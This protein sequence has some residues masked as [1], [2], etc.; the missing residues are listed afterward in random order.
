MLKKLSTTAL[1][2]IALLTISCTGFANTSS[3]TTRTYSIQDLK[4]VVTNDQS[5]RPIFNALKT[6]AK[7]NIQ[8]T[9]KSTGTQGHFKM[10]DPTGTIQ[11]PTFTVLKENTDSHSVNRVGMGS[12]T[13]NQQKIDYVIQVGIDLNKPVDHY[14][15]PMILSSDTKLCYYS[16]LLKPSNETTMRFKKNIAAKST[17]QGSDLTQ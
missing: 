11:N 5:C 9:F 6:M 12:F 16:A 7:D 8:L 2:T 3:N 15:Y 14:L 4:R 13:L 10:M 1:T 17:E